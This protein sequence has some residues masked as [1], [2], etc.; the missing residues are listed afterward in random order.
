MIRVVLSHLVL[1]LLPFI[2]YAVYLFLKKKAQTKENWQAGP[3]PW[4]ALTGL[5]LVLGGLVFFASF[6]Q[7]PEG[8]E[9]R[10]SQMRDGVFVPGGYE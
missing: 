5:V 10:P 1:F 2:G 9:Y 6:K 4:L 7:M 8:T 3:M